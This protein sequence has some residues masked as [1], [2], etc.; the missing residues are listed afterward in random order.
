MLTEP[1]R[2]LGH[3]LAAEWLA[4]VGE[5]DPVVLAEH[6]ER[7]GET[8]RA[9]TWYQRAAEQALEG[10]DLDAALAWIE[11]AKACGARGQALGA[12]HLLAAEA[13]RWRGDAVREQAEA[14]RA[15]DELDMG[16]DTW[17]AAV[18]QVAA[19]SGRRGD[20]RQLER[21]AGALVEVARRRAEVAPLP[22]VGSAARLSA[23]LARAAVGLMLSGCRERADALLE[24]LAALGD[25][26]TS[27]SPSAWIVHVAHS[28]RAMMDGDT[29]A[30][31]ELTRAVVERV[32]AAGNVRAGC[33][34][35]VNVG[36]MCLELGRYDEAE[37][38]LRDV[39]ATAEDMGLG[40][41]V[42]G[43]R[44]CVGHA[45]LRRGAFDE[46]RALLSAA[47]EELSRGG[48]RR[49][50]ENA[51]CDLALALL[52]GGDVR[53]AEAIARA[54]VEA[55]EGIPTARS[56]A[57]ATLARALLD[58]NRE[59]EALD[60]AREAA[61]ALDAVG[62]VDHG[63]AFIRLTVAQALHAAWEMDDA[64]SAIRAARDRLLRRAGKIGDPELRE[65]FLSGVRENAETLRLA[66]VWD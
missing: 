11:R 56:Y 65:G 19:A 4:E 10:N 36:W 45:L 9:V 48:I 5:R 30:A 28:T 2:Q 29:S 24:Q 39:L 12:L 23:A 21:V 57:L 32:E 59:G 26:A 51:R 14:L 49:D 35:R 3:K 54:A 22:A 16:A 33:A 18:A 40:F 52:G 20:R 42:A 46:A 37:A 27:E 63:D 43:A 38:A 50:A 31:L 58:T 25:E 66:E 47:H 53:G 7:G 1:D 60:P 15:M 62:G 61:A 41:V 44:A 17:L 34:A 8:T 55:T 64:R 6:L 13:H